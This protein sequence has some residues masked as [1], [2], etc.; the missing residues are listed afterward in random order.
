MKTKIRCG[1]LNVKSFLFRFPLGVLEGNY[2]IPSAGRRKLELKLAGV[3]Q[4]KKEQTT[5][6]LIH[7]ETSTFCFPC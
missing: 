5:T 2:L 1:Q 6:T 7:K 4:L 3:Y